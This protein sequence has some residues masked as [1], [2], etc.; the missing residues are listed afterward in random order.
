M[1]EFSD[2]IRTIGVIGSCSRP[3]ATDGR[4]QQGRRYRA[5]TDELG[6]TT[7]EYDDHQDV[8]IRAATVTATTRS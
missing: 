8:T 2:K 1:S 4:D 6:N 5:T 3:H 7:T